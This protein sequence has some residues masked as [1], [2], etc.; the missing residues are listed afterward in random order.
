MN[1]LS[2]FRQGP[3]CHRCLHDKNA[4]RPENSW[5][6]LD[7]A[8]ERGL[9][10]EIDLQ[11][12]ADG[13][14]MVFHDETLDRLTEESGAVNARNAAEL[15]RIPLTGGSKPIPIFSDFVRYVDGRVPLLVELKDQDGALGNAE[16]ELEKSVCDTLLGYSSDVA[17]MSFNPHII[18]RCAE[19]APDIPRGLVTD[20]F[21]ATDWPDVS[22]SRREQ[23]AQ[24][25]D[26]E[27]IG[28]TFISHN[29]NDLESEAVAK[30]KD[31]GGDVYCWT[32]RSQEQEDIARKI[33]DSVTFEG[34]TPRDIS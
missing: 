11:V 20:L 8:I 18:A 26:Y 17:L 10:V 22:R 16:S 7:A 33:A 5:E 24:I 32:V 4:G 1:D 15:S 12:S 13:H 29:V 3:I 6:A 31:S 30:I 21:S 19:L 2:A 25:P 27:A 28:A 14:A 9:A 23:L 34:Y